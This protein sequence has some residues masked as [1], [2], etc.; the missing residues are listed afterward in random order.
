M[1][2]GP[3]LDVV[4]A[5]HDP[6]RRVDRALASLADPSGRARVTIVC[7]GLTTETVAEAIGEYDRS[8]VRLVPFDDGIPSPSG[9][10]NHGLALAT[11]DYVM[12][13]G[14]DDFL[15]PGALGAWMDAVTAS[16][17]DVQLVAL[18]YQGGALLANPL[19]RPWR[20]RRLNAVRDRLFHRT[21]PLALIRRDLI[22][23]C[24]GPLSPGMP[25]GG[26]LAWS[27]AL[28]TAPV[29]IDFDPRHPAYVIGA[30]AETRVTT[31]PR[32]LGAVLDPVDALLGNPWAAR[33]P[34]PVRTSLV[35]KLLRV[36]V[37]GAIRSRPSAQAWPHE[38]RERI[39]ATVSAA[40][41]YGP[42]GFDDLPRA[43]RDLLDAVTAAGARADD[44]AA[45]LVRY[46]G[47]GRAARLLPRRLS[48][49]FGRESVLRRYA[50][51]TVDRR[52]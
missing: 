34:R 31:Q 47:A 26:D 9:P 37:I 32:A 36:N 45:A 1:T 17:A 50:R 42:A 46:R 18:R 24:E 51:Y 7:H 48:R 15:E 10:F 38:D 39:A 40:R 43:D 29:R 14:S 35:A 44:I 19:T 2:D 12:I 27:S 30:D 21:A 20:R 8:A 16:R 13:M 22:A 33:Q 41:S 11:G 5:V 49:A 3:L 28:W 4:I 23:L 6:G 52:G 25:V